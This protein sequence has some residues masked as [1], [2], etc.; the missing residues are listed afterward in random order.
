MSGVWNKFIFPTLKDEENVDV[1][2]CVI[3]LFVHITLIY[4]E[5][6]TTTK[7]SLEREKKRDHSFSVPF[8]WFAFFCWNSMNI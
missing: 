2:L 8:T 7:T 3:L 1:R 4:N 5:P 6:K